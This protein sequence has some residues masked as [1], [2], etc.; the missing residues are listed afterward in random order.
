[1]D[2]IE[3]LYTSRKVS[4]YNAKICEWLPL[5]HLLARLNVLK[6]YSLVL[7][8]DIKTHGKDIVSPRH[9]K[10]PKNVMQ[11]LATH[12]FSRCIAYKRQRD[13]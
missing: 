12:I 1:M 7:N 10:T 11:I 8:S 4:V 6:H 13:K 2:G 5:A 3:S 9:L